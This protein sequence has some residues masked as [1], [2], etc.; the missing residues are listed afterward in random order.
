MAWSLSLASASL[1]PF[2]VASWLGSSGVHNSHH[3]DTSLA[4]D[5]RSAADDSAGTKD[6]GVDV[7]EDDEAVDVN[8]NPLASWNDNS[9]G[10][11]DGGPITE[12]AARQWNPRNFMRPDD[13]RSDYESPYEHGDQTP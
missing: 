11:N 8:G 7:T 3:V 9:D 6:N 12:E 5:E 2:A 13:W 10:L 4:A 1:K